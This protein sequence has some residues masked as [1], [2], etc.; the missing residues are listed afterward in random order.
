LGGVD[1]MLAPHINFL[2]WS[3]KT[4]KILVVH[5]LSFLRHKEFFS[6]RKNIWHRLLKVKKI[7]SQADMIV[8]VS[9]STKR[10]LVELLEIPEEKVVV[11]HSG[12]DALEIS[13][14]DITR[15][16]DKYLLPEKYLLYLGNIEPRKNIINLIKAF[17]VIKQTKLLA[18]Y[19]LILGGS[20]AWKVKEIKNT[21]MQ[22]KF[23]DDIRFLGYVDYNDKGALYSLA[24]AF[25]YP[26]YYEG[27]GFPPLEAMSYGCPV[28]ASNLSSLPEILGE[29]AL[30]VNP[31]DYHDIAQTTITL[32]NDKVLA[33]LI[34]ERAFNHVKNFSWDKT[35]AAYEKLF[36]VICQKK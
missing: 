21:W 35:A 11:I 7:V 30:Y 26:S 3:N 34:R 5:D 23:R 36:N 31:F 33:D 4:K 22:S 25:V 2:S 16:K 13:S 14:K 27:F 20:W 8:A 6:W 24:K 18:D 32:L 9:Y 17:E 28:I 19:K 15:V 10:E 1:I 29:A 12:I